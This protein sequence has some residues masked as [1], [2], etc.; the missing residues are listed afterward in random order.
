VACSTST[1]AAPPESVGFCTPHV[2]W[3]ASAIA[4]R[5]TLT[6][7]PLGV[8][9]FA[10]PKTA[11]GR[12]VVPLPP[13]AMAALRAQRARQNADRRALGP[14]YADYGLVFATRLGTA[15]QA[16][17]VIRSFKALLERA[18]LPRALRVHDLRHT[19]ASLLLAHGADVP[20]TAAI[21][22]H[23]QS[24]TTLNVYAHA[25]PSRLAGAAARLGSA[26]QGVEPEPPSSRITDGL[27]EPGRLPPP[28]SSPAD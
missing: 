11:R 1:S 20:T 7:A 2:D 27:P 16:R 15:L 18:G 28:E 4:V 5:R 8:P 14:D 3:E 10:E 9:A 24:S 6:K 26:I 12:R 22:G 19:T 13:L 21:L 23:A 25:L 17:N